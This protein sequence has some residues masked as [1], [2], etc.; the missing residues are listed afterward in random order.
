MSDRYAFTAPQPVATYY[1]GDVY[2]RFSVIRSAQS[3]TSGREIIGGTPIRCS[4][5]CPR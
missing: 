1:T 5:S 2:W 4:T 3:A